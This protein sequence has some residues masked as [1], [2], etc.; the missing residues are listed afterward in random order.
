MRSIGKQSPSA[1]ALGMRAAVVLEPDENGRDVPPL[2][3]SASPNEHA[4]IVDATRP[5]RLVVE[6][7][8]DSA[9]VLVVADTYYPGWKAM[10]D[11][12]PASI[13][14]AKLLFRAVYVPAGRHRV[15]LSYEP[16]SFL[17]G[18]VLSVLGA[19]LISLMLLRARVGSRR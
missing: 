6:A 7:N 17:A 19:L 10:V 3:G 15:V 1:E 16:R 2:S 4:R 11:A 5:D 9:G 13:F 14:P 8:L 18:V 12:A